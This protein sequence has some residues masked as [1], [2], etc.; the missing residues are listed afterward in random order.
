MYLNYTH[1]TQNDSLHKYSP[2]SGQ[3]LVEPLL[4][5]TP[6]IRFAHLDAPLYIPFYIRKTSQALWSCMVNVSEQN[7]VNF[8]AMPSAS[9]AFIWVFLAVAS[10]LL[11]SLRHPGN[12]CCM[13]SAHNSAMKPCN[14]L[15][16]DLQ[17]HRSIFFPFFMIDLTLLWGNIQCV[18][19]FLVS[20]PWFKLF[21]NFPAD[22]LSS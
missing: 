13:H 21:S 6:G 16:A 22:W 2:P 12:S 15:Q 14:L 8:Q 20:F 4:A 11:L 5:G 9:A 1:E 10:S 17:L 19:Y 3:Y 7:R 18:G